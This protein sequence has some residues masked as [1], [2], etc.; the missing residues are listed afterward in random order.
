MK[1]QCKREERL[2]IANDIL[3]NNETL[4]ILEVKVAKLHKFYLGISIND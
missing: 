3:P 4:D 2:S 1:S